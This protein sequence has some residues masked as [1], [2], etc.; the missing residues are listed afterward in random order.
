MRLRF[1]SIRDNLSGIFLAPFVA[2]ND[3]EGVRNLQASL[4]DPRMAESAIVM[5]PHDFQLMYVGSFDDETGRMYPETHSAG[6][7][8]ASLGLVARLCEVNYER[9][10]VE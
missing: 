1:Y 8:P 3:V 5:S 6:P 7:L 10:P 2:R 9:P 4:K